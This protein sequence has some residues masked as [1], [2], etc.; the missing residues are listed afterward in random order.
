MRE[1]G[2]LGPTVW[3][4]IWDACPRVSLGLPIIKWACPGAQA[5]HVTVCGN[6]DPEKMLK[7][8]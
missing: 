7:I 5:L 2:Y 4:G 8:T 1:A 6:D 3:A